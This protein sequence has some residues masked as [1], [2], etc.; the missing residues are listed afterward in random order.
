MDDAKASG[1]DA[2]EPRQSRAEA[3]ELGH[4]AYLLAQLEAANQ[5]GV[6]PDEAYNRILS[7]SGARR[8]SLIRA[9]RHRGL[10][11]AA[12][13]QLTLGHPE[14]ALDYA[15]A[16]IELDPEPSECWELALDLLNNL[17]RRDEAA[18]LRAEAEGR[19]VV[20]RPRADERKAAGPTVPERTPS[21]REVAESRA[22]EPVFSLLEV[23][24]PV[25]VTKPPPTPLPVQAPVSWGSIAGEFLQDHWQKLILCLAVLLI[26]VS[27]TVGAQ[28][29]LGERLLWSRGGQCLLALVYTAMF[30]AFGAGLI[31]WGANRAG[32]IMLATSLLVVPVNFGLAGE[33]RLL[34]SLSPAHLAIFALMTVVLAV[35]CWGTAAILGLR[36]GLAFPLTFFLLAAF[37]SLAASGSPFALQFS[38]LIAAAG[39]FLVAVWLLTARVKKPEETDA[40]ALYFSLG[41]LV[42]A[43]LFFMGRCGVFTLGLLTHAPTLLALPTM[44]AGVACV[45]AAH[46]LP[47]IEK[48]PRRIVLLRIAGLT[49]AGLAFALALAHPPLAGPLLSGNTLATALLGLA[50]FTALLWIERLPYALY[51]AFAALLIA[52][53]G[54]FYFVRDMMDSVRSHL[55]HLL[56]YQGRL[57]DPFKALNG[58]VFNVFL[59]ALASWFRKVWRDDRLAWHCHAI[60]LPL[61]ISACVFSGLEPKAALLCLPAYAA[62]FAVASWF[63][64][65]PRLIYL[66]CAAVVGAASFG[67]WLAL[68]LT[69]G[70]WALAAVALGFLFWLIA[71]LLARFHVDD[72]YRLPLD[73]AALGVSALSLGA[74]CIAMLP[75]HALTPAIIGTFFALAVLGAVVGL[76]TPERRLADCALSALA[77]GLLLLGAVPFGG[78]LLDATP[79]R[80]AL[81]CGAVGLGYSLGGKG[82]E[83]L[84]RVRSPRLER[85]SRAGFYIQPAWR[86]A[87]LLAVL[88]VT[89]A[90]GDRVLDAAWD[91]WA[92]AGRGV[93]LILV[94]M[95]LVVLLR[96]HAIQPLAHMTWLAAAGAW[97]SGFEQGW[98]LGFEPGKGPSS[99]AWYA[100]V[101]AGF[102]S[103]AM[104]WAE[105][106]RGWDSPRARAA[107]GALPGF[108][109]ALLAV[110]IGLLFFGWENTP[111]VVAALVVGAVVA[112]WLTRLA[113]DPALVY[114]A[115]AQGVVAAMC[116]TALVTGWSRP[117]V[118]WGWIAVA[119]SLAML[120]LW[121]VAWLGR[122]RR[123]PALIAVPCAVSVLILGAVVPALVVMA[124]ARTIDAYPPGLAALLIS[125]AA[126]GLLTIASRVP[127]P[128]W[129]AI[130]TAAGAVVLFLSSTTRFPFERETFGIAAVL[131]GLGFWWLGRLSDFLLDR[132]W[133]RLYARPLYDATQVLTVPAVLMGWDS[134]WTMALVGVAFLLMLRSHPATRWLYAAQAAFVMAGYQAALLD[135]PVWALMLAATAGAFLLI[136]IAWLIRRDGNR[137]GSR[138][139][140][141]DLPYDAPLTH[142]AAALAAFGAI[143]AIKSRPVLPAAP[144]TLALA[145]G[146]FTILARR[147]RKEAAFHAVAASLAWVFLPPWTLWALLDWLAISHTALW[148]NL[149]ALAGLAAAAALLW[150]S[151][152][153]RA[154]QAAWTALAIEAVAAVAAGYAA[155]VVVF[156]LPES[157]GSM[158]AGWIGLTVL[159][160]LGGMLALL[161]WRLRWEWLVLAA[162]A[163]LVG[164][165]FYSRVAFSTSAATDAIVLVLLAYLNFGIAEVMARSGWDFFARPMLSFALI[166][167][168][169]PLGLAFRGGGAGNANL[170]TLFAGAVY[171]AVAGGRLKAGRWGYAA[172]VLFNAFLW[173][174]WARVGWR[175]ADHPQ[176]YMVPVGLSV[177]LLAEI[178]RRE[179][180]RTFTNGLRVV[181]LTLV[182]ASLAVPLWQTQGL[183]AW[184][185][186]LVLSLAGIL[187]GIGLQVQSFLWFGLACFVLDVVYQLGRMGTQNTLAKWGIMLG[188][189]LGLVLFVALNEKRKIVAT[190]RAYYE[191]ARQWE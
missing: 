21:S 154:G 169:F 161:A 112:L 16:A 17:G 83:W 70:G 127:L 90:A 189:G 105:I 117:G 76:D 91:A 158:A 165:Y 32:Q 52:Y 142:G 59:A 71:R 186:L 151:R 72:A 5:R 144:L 41:L 81:T 88:A 50:L 118:A 175:L 66:A 135:R 166:M 57:P 185:T 15:K 184:A 126:L 102:G 27:S 172:A 14:R 65:E 115:I 58:V 183:A 2:V 54:T 80:L 84:H 107:R 9:G 18:A 60:G 123:V 99:T 121:A 28:N 46:V 20:L 140:L 174:F 34:S 152:R 149:K 73:H 163:V 22:D 96:S 67:L 100:L 113:P 122:E 86:L 1:T 162:Q 128:T 47:K 30:T 136:G 110:A 23:E 97:I 157:A 31:R 156:A 89:A 155:A 62:L 108:L 75:P 6:L 25:R 176:F 119:V 36:R 150:V 160:G 37:N 79:L 131:L 109:V 43:F 55:G 178:N 56:G 40:A 145:T 170:F 68:D 147:Q 12:F 77:V 4:I 74:V 129:A 125:A 124:R 63:F 181:G 93:A 116:G 51:L 103:A 141:L 44:F 138:L 85:A 187:V 137:M 8:E 120:V 61:A 35:I 45:R 29:L 114:L 39:L 167:P 148:T 82:A 159:L 168:L 143:L 191:K 179:L 177:V 92:P 153:A 11:G 7:E 146:A 87:L 182:Y 24:E 132:D 164:A 10:V 134:A 13:T 180:G 94:A 133:D 42:Y 173:L 48:D 130:A 104:S 111:T 106:T 33:L 69:L 101:I 139:G 38:A 19:G 78:S 26:V 95:T 3:E 53:F 190:M 171:Y 64:A 188:L 98:N 49:F